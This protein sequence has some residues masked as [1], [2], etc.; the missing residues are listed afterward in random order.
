MDIAQADTEK[1]R[2]P[3]YKTTLTPFPLQFVSMTQTRKSHLPN[4]RNKFD[5]A[6]EQKAWFLSSHTTETSTRMKQK[7]N[8]KFTFFG[9]TSIARGLVGM[10]EMKFL[11][12]IARLLLPT[13]LYHFQWAKNWTPVRVQATNCRFTNMQFYFRFPSY[14]R[15]RT[16]IFDFPHTHIHIYSLRA[17]SFSNYASIFILFWI[18]NWLDWTLYASVINSLFL[19]HN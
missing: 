16:Y 15:T 19:V 13:T 7:Q 6:L 8:K 11:C 18:S 1:V 17:R 5:D 2:L 9:G 4:K 10:M 3:A 14:T 12:V